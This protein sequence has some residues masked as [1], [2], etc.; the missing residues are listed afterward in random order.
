MSYED[1]L[2]GVEYVGRV[3]GYKNVDLEFEL[4][5]VWDDYYVNVWRDGVE[6][7][8]HLSSRGDFEDVWGWLETF[9]PDVDWDEQEF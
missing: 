6:V 9:Y 8:S 7:A 4:V 2:Q 1:L 5:W 3:C